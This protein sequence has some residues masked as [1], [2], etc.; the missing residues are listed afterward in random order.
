MGIWK[1]KLDYTL[2]TQCNKLIRKNSTSQ[3]AFTE[4]GITPKLSFDQ[5]FCTKLQCTTTPSRV[6]A[7]EEVGP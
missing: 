2:D 7:I 3:L 6:V 5:S 1:F 4:E